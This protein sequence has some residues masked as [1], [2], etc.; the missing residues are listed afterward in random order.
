MKPEDKQKDTCKKVLGRTYYDPRTR[1]WTFPDGS[2]SIP[3]EMYIDIRDASKIYNSAGSN[4]ASV[5]GTLFE[6]KRRLLS[7]CSPDGQKNRY[8]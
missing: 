2:G 7:K 4:G 3:Q 1:T 5:L 6:W 8:S